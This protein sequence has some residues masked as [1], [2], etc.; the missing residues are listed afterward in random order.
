MDEC[1]EALGRQKVSLLQML[2][3]DTDKRNSKSKT[4][5]KPHGSLTSAYIVSFE[6]GL[7]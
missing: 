7:V 2:T 5:T 4:E 6:L 3:E 1:I